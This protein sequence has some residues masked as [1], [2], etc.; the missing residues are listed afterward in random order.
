[1]SRERRA[2]AWDHGALA[3]QS[4]GGMLG[5]ALFLLPD[6][7][8]VA[9]LQ[10]A[11]WGN[12]PARSDLPGVLRELRGD[13]ACVPFGF[14][15]PRDLTDGWHA[16]G[17]TFAGAGLAH[18]VSS[19]TDWDVVEQTEAR[20]VLACP[21]PDDHPVRLVRRSI[22]PDPYAPAVDI[23]LEIAVRRPCRLPVGVHP[24]FRL[25]P[26]TGSVA[27]EL[28]EYRSIYT[29]PGDLEPGS[30]LFTP[31]VQFANLAEAPVRQGGTVDVSALPLVVDFED[32]VQVAGLGGEVAL[33]YRDEGFRAR[34][35]WDPQHF[36]SALIWMS[37]RGRRAW[38]WSGR[39]L[40]I[41][42][43]PVASAFD[44]G[45]AI[46]TGNNP[47]ARSGIA[48]ALALAPELPFRTTYR[49]A[50]EPA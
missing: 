9:P 20:L 46:A 7:R 26:R 22:A 28:A 2:L 8:Q 11:A 34:L 42:I 4:L 13:W 37:N 44:L 30:A 40:A 49:I 25:P 43:E 45:P 29:F 24:T 17:E 39:H 19:N 47:V 3:V 16:D 48:T 35:S 41:G 21:Y 14:D 38:P 12:D 10:V 15:G 18:G 50:V 1:M 32:L 27:I 31:G 6:G 5:P 33:H 23:T 36:P